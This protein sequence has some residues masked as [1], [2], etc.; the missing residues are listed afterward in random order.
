MK[1]MAA[2]DSEGIDLAAAITLAHIDPTLPEVAPRLIAAFDA[3][4]QDDDYR[5]A[6]HRL[7]PASA[8]LL[9]RLMARIEAGDENLY[10]VISGM[11]PA[12]RPAVPLLLAGLTQSDNVYG[13][14]DALQSLSE[15]APE[16]GQQILADLQDEDRRLLA[17]GH[18]NILGPG[19]AAAL[20]TLISLSTGTDAQWRS[21]AIDAL[22]RIPGHDQD[23]APVLAAALGDANPRIVTAA[24][25]A[26]ASHAKGAEPVLPQ[27]LA[28]IES[29]DKSS[30]WAL[31][32]VAQEMGPAAKVAVP[33]L[34][35]Q[36]QG[37]DRRLSRAIRQAID[38]IEG[39]DGEEKK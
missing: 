15:V 17:I 26:L 8:E 2:P 39:Q 11:G 13:V 27:L 31:V 25:N 38:A 21:A 32:R 4:R 33:V 12:A 16:I 1:K 36:L 22:G 10:G 6:L 19:A 34:Q 29:S 23:I 14:R 20:P 9:P 35:M 7:G 5:N 37:S 18:L 30:K 28:A 24:A 3:N